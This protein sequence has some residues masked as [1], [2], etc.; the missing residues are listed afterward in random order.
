MLHTWSQQQQVP[1]Q[2]QQVVQPGT[3]NSSSMANIYSSTRPLHGSGPQ[4]QQ[5]NEMSEFAYNQVCAE[6]PA[7]Q[8]VCAAAAV[9]VAQ[10]VQACMHAVAQAVQVQLD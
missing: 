10:H 8:V 9:T 5:Y 7:D 6:T 2:Q 4:T 3:C 1:A